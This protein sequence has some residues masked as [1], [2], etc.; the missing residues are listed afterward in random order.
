LCENSDEIVIPRYDGSRADLAGVRE[1]LLKGYYR[2]VR[3]ATYEGWLYLSF[4]SKKTSV[5]HAL[6]S[7]ANV[8]EHVPLSTGIL[9]T[10][11]FSGIYFFKS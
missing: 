3:M 10:I 7:A 6:W 8:T 2:Q 11:N 1:A 9:D 5:R 4:T